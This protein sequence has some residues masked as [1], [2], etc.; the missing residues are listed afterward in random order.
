MTSLASPLTLRCGLTLKNRCLLAPLTNTQ[1]HENGVLS[2]E[3]LRWLTMRAEGGFAMTRTC[4]AHVR[5]DGKG[6][7]GQLGV[8]SDDHLPGLSRL[9]S[10]IKRHDSIAIAQLHHAGMRSPAELIGTTPLCPSENEKT[11]ARAMSSPEV[12]EAIEAFIAA[13]ERCQTAGFDGVEI[14]GA[15]G[16]LLAQFLSATINQREDDYG[17]SLENRARIVREITSGIRSRCGSDFCVGLR[18][19]AERFGIA[20]GDMLELSGELMAEKQLDFLDISLWDVF[21][22][23]AEEAFQEKSLLDWFAELDRYGTRLTV[24]GKIRTSRDVQRVLDASVDAVMIGQAA[25]L[26]HDLP[27]RAIDDAAFE[28]TPLPVSRSYLDR[29]GVSA[30]FVEYLNR[31]PDFVAG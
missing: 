24:A 31:W 12:Q 10:G 1:S 23:P 8:F 26:H 4:A 18:L 5:A 27:R 9:A 20:M 6:F 14:H 19:S 15:H 21:K 30:K 13:A 16:Y 2:D 25:I 7:P 28:P 3:E 11:G 22:A 29:E 17:G